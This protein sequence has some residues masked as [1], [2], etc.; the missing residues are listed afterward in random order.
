MQP[1]H[2]NINVEKIWDV[3]LQKAF[4]YG[5]KTHIKQSNIRSIE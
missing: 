2:I 5:L 1:A 4:A 3:L